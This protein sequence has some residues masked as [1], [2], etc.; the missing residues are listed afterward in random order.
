MPKKKSTT[1]SKTTAK[2]KS[3]TKKVV[4]KK[5]KSSSQKKED[6]NPSDFLQ[7]ENENQLKAIITKEF[8]KDLTEKSLL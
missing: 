3:T 8:D 4:E 2:K 6:I 5:T 1:L 7:I